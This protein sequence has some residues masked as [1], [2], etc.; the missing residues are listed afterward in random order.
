M[1]KMAKVELKEYAKQV[2]VDKVGQRIVAEMD[3]RLQ[4]VAG[5]MNIEADKIG[6][7]IGDLWE[8]LES[9]ENACPCK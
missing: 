1:K 2:D 4:S 9:L 7:S 8:R 3:E 6:K 5:R